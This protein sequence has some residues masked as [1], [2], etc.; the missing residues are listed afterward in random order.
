M[1]FIFRAEECAP[2]LIMDLAQTSETIL[3]NFSFQLS[4][5]T[6]ILYKLYEKSN[7]I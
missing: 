4:G 2:I 1:R 6:T 5:R 7:A 3:T